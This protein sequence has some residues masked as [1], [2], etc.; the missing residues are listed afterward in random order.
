MVIV[1]ILPG[2][3]G[4]NTPRIIRGLNIFLGGRNI[5]TL[6]PSAVYDPGCSRLPRSRLC[7]TSSF[8]VAVNNS[9][10]VVHCSGHTTLSGGT[11]L[12]VGTNHV[13]CLTS[14]RRGR[15][16]LVAGLVGNSCG[17]RG[18]VVLG[19]RFCRGSGMVNRCST[20]GSTIVADNFVSEVVSVSIT[21]RGSTIGCHT[22]NLVVSAP[23]NSA[24]CSV[25]TNKPVVSPTA[26][27]VYV[28]PVYSRSLS[29]GPVLVDTS[30]ALALGSFSGG[31][32]RVC[33]AISNEGITGVGPCDRVGVAGSGSFI[34]LVQLDSHSFCGAV[35]MGFG[36]DEDIWF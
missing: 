1:N 26:R 22:S 17:V 20:L 23:A 10:A 29:T 13:N 19:I 18:E 27:G 24:T 14:V 31:H 33:L 16:N 15:L 21:I 25:S 12:K 7:G 30:A 5:G 28:A 9:N 8:V 6:L 11:I 3:R 32:A 2:L 35:S 34:R 4:H 36:S